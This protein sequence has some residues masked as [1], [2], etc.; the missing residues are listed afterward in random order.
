MANWESTG[1]KPKLPEDY[2]DLSIGAKA[3]ALWHSWFEFDGNP[4]E[5]CEIYD[6][7][8]FCGNDA[9]S[10]HGDT[11]AYVLACK[12]LGVEQKW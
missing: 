12:L 10:G 9:A 4:M 6:W 5:Y 1:L 7:C 2:D 3:L 11:C 8:T